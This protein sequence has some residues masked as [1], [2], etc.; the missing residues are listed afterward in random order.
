MTGDVYT[1]EGCAYYVMLQFRFISVAA[2]FPV[3][4]KR[5]PCSPCYRKAHS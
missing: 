4:S 3:C 1:F 2:S 5:S